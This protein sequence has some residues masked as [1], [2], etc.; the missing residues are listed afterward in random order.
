MKNI[1][2]THVINVIQ[3]NNIDNSFRM[4]YNVTINNKNIHSKGV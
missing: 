2:V 1:N 3:I 4:I